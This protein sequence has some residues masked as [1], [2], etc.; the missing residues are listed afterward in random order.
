MNEERVEGWGAG[1][2]QS[3]QCRRRRLRQL[4][5]TITAKRPLRFFGYA[6]VH[7][8]GAAA[9]PFATQDALLTALQAWGIPVAPHRVLCRTLADVNAWATRVEQEFRARS[10]SRSTAPW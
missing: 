10:T 6:A 5:S 8:D 7:P 3:A 9:L 1:V 4:D 2:R